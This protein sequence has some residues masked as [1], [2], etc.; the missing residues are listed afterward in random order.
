[1]ESTT[2]IGIVLIVLGFIDIVLGNFLIG[3]RLKGTPRGSVITTMTVLSGVLMQL[4]G[5]ALIMGL[6]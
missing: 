1:M 3:P 5:A 2:L 6:L 4:V